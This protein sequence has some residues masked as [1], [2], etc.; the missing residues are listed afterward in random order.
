MGPPG[1]L[2]KQTNP[3]SSLPFPAS[4]PAH[5][6]HHVVTLKVCLQRAR[7]LLED[8]VVLVRVR[9]ALQVAVLGRPVQLL[10]LLFGGRVKWEG[11]V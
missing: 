4:A 7:R 8:E 5:L 11:D 6:D 3:S 2:S 10:L 9:E 1:H